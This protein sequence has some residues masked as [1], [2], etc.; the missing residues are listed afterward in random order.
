MNRKREVAKFAAGAAFW[1]AAGHLMLAFSGLLPLTV[2]GI[3]VSPTLNAVWIAI[4][5]WYQPG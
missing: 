1:E 4:M 3:T 2:W 5:L